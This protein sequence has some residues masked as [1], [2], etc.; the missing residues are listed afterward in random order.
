LSN[1]KKLSL[2]SYITFI[3]T[4]VIALISFVSVLFPAFLPES[5]SSFPNPN[6]NPYEFGLWAYPVLVSNIIFL[7]I[8]IAYRK[9]KLPQ[10]VISLINFV[11][12]FETSQ[13]ITAIVIIVLI[14]FY[15]IFSVDELYR[16]E[17]E[18]G[19]YRQV[20][21]VVENWTF[22]EFNISVGPQLRYF[23]L[24]TSFLIL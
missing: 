17:Y 20:K 3:F 5:L 14:G 18:L 16:E 12:N 8:G 2:V 10:Q 15:I 1:L 4:F 9:N 23:L 19:D 6:S 7:V 22:N 11:L 24:H 13:K 21:E